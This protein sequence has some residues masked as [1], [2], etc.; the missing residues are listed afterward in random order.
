MGYPSLIYSHGWVVGLWIAGYMLVPLS[1]F[2]VL[3]KRFAQLSHR[4]GAITV[5]DL[6]RAVCQPATGLGVVAVDHLPHVVLDDRP[7]QSRRDRDEIGLAELRF[8][9]PGRRFSRRRPASLRPN[10][11]Q[12]P[13]CCAAESTGGVDRGT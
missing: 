1:G 5:P 4:T 2:A 7:I 13:S 6:F 10:R 9:E 8:A 11:D 3:G 12:S